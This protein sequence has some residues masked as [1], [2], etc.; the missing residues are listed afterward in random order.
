MKSQQ[1]PQRKRRKKTATTS[2]ENSL[3]ES[4][5]R[6]VVGIDEVGRGAWA[7]PVAVGAFVYSTDS[8]RVQGVADSKL[9]TITARDAL[10]TKLQE[11]TNCVSF[12]SL[13]R[14]NRIGVG[15]TIEFLI[16]SLISRFDDGETYFL[17]D[18]RFAP[19]FHANS[20]QIIGGDTKHY[21]IAAASVLS[22]V[23]R[24]DLM[25]RFAKRY[26]AYGFSTNVGYPTESHRSA[27]K[28]SGPSALHRKSFR[29]IAELLEQ[30]TLWQ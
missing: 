30:Q 26:P 5:F 25:K 2:L 21:S 11:H 8:S 6:R 18:G 15:K 23:A 10:A 29:P 12:G 16:S 3:F 13:A 1:K 4:G 24:D 20:M 27:L 9:L 7:G 22:K 19:S 17:V 28:D 14:I